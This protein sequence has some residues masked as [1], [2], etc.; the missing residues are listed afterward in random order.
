[1]GKTQC[2]SNSE[3]EKQVLHATQNGKV[4]KKECGRCFKMASMTD[5]LQGKLDEKIW[6][7]FMLS[8][9]K[10]QL[11][12]YVEY[13]EERLRDAEKTATDF[14]LSTSSD[15]TTHHHK[16]DDIHMTGSVSCQTEETTYPVGPVKEEVKV[17][18]PTLPTLPLTTNIKKRRNGNKCICFW[19]LTHHVD[20]KTYSRHAESCE[21]RLAA[22]DK[23]L[24]CD[25]FKMTYSSFSSSSQIKCN[26]CKSSIPKRIWEKHSVKCMR[27]KFQIHC[28]C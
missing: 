13:L 21:V 25:G 6:K 22:N 7:S 5:L 15:T 23:C 12:E 14:M 9:Q 17:E 18:I 27:K 8:E 28:T 2:K 16:E 20:I 24:V 1:M 11:E 26:L 4:E 3:S 19:C 10:R